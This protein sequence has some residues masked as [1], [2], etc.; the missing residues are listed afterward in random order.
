MKRLKYYMLQMENDTATYQKMYEGI[1][2]NP[3]K[4]PG[5]PTDSA[6]VEYDPKYWSGDVAFEI[7]ATNKLKK[8]RPTLTLRIPAEKL[9]ITDSST[10][11][12]DCCLRAFLPYIDALNGDL[13][14]RSRPDEENGKYFLYHPGGEILERNSVFFSMFPPKDYRNGNGNIIYLLP[15]EDCGSPRLCLCFRM[16][17]Q[18]PK[19]KLRKSIQMLCNDLPDAVER[20]IAEFDHAAFENAARLGQKQAAI[21][22]WLKGSGYCAFLANGSV[23][24][25]A[26]GTDLAM[27]NAVPFRSTPE[28]E[29]EVCGVQGMGIIKGVTVITGGGYSGKSTLL[30]AISAGIYDHAPGDGRELC[31]TDSHAVT[32]SAEDGRSVMHCNISPFIQWLPGGDTAD[33]STDRASGST[34]QAANIMEAVDFGA[35]LLLID[36]DRSATNFMIRDSRMK[37]LIR[38]EPIVPFTDRVNELF[39]EKDVSTILVIGGSGEYLSVADKV[40][41][42]EDFQ[43]HDVTKEAKEI[44]LEEEVP[45]AKEGATTE[46]FCTMEQICP[47]K[48]VPTANFVRRADWGQHRILHRDGFS[49]YPEGSGSE[50]L[51]VSDLGFICIGD[52]RIDIRGLHDIITG[53]QL[54]ALGYMLRYLEIS[55]RD[56][57]IDLKRQIDDLYEKIGQEGLDC[58]FSSYFTATG[59]FLDLPRKQ[60]L[61]MLV[62]RMRKI[63]FQKGR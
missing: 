49:S 32:V 10:A 19:K 5:N 1:T 21:R 46:Q 11:A 53:G 60:E 33:F 2:V 6:I 3:P 51:L 18:L 35:K 16:Q 26:K 34:S 30:D 43:I 54:D 63:H 24:P 57:I 48:Q 45:T 15:G 12:A 47:E 36:E 52:E 31:I 8:D 38:N 42:M 41:L 44:C 9:G 59:R 55:N 4:A 62:S 56:Q 25:R 40:Y 23:L 50:R 13:Y 20:F 39:R 17:V 37:E 7:S 28:D 22:Q 14:N 27:E 29:I 58:V 61:M